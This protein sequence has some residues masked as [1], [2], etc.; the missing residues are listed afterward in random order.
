VPVGQSQARPGE[1]AVLAI[2]PEKLRIASEVPD[3]D[4]NGLRG[5]LIAESYAGDRS[6]YFLDIEGL[7]RQL[8]VAN[9]NERQSS[10]RLRIDSVEEVWVVWPVESGLLLTS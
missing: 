6:Y 3:G 8:T 2:R 9:L 10:T 5:K 1:K 7:S 4:Y